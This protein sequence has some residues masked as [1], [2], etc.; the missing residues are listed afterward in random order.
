VAA[1]PLRHHYV[2]LLPISA[3]AG[4]GQGSGWVRR[5]LRCD[6][7]DG[8]KA[9]HSAGAP[10]K[11][12]AAVLGSWL[13]IATDV[14]GML[15]SS[16]APVN[17]AVRSHWRERRLTVLSVGPAPAESAMGPMEKMPGDG[18]ER[19]FELLLRFR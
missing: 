10:L 1:S 6:Q 12:G 16:E 11:N 9:A 7:T 18:E 2:V 5:R 3:A 14:A 15:G 19:S 4:F 13:K 17:K 8:E